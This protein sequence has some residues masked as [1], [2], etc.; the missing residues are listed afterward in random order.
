[1]P[2]S[3]FSMTVFHGNSAFSWNTK[4]MSRGQRSAHRLAQHV[5]AARAR[6][7]QSADHVEERALAAAA[8][9]DQAQ[10]LAA[11]HL[12]R[13]VEQRA[14]ETLLARLAELMG[15]AAHPDRDFLRDHPDTL[16]DLRCGAAGPSRHLRTGCAGRARAKYFPGERCRVNSSAGRPR[17]KACSCRASPAGA[18]ISTKERAS[19]SSALASNR[20]V[21]LNTGISSS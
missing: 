15:N 5:D 10:Q 6:L 9:P 8:R 3:M 16:F 1:M 13:G 12:E 17:C 7:R 11:R 19:T 21:L 20:P 14:H 2:S 18:P 4:A